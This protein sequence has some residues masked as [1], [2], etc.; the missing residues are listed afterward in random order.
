MPKILSEQRAITL[1]ITFDRE[2]TRQEVYNGIRDKILS[3]PEIKSYLICEEY[4]DKTGVPHF[5]GWVKATM[6]APTLKKRIRETFPLYVENTT[7][8]SAADVKKDSYFHYVLKGTP[9]DPP[10]VVFKQ[11][12]DYPEDVIQTHWQEAQ[13]MFHSSTSKT[14]RGPSATAIVDEVYQWAQDQQYENAYSDEAQMA[15]CG[16]LHEIYLDRKKS[17]NNFHLQSQLRWVMCKMSWKYLAE[18]T[19]R[20][21][22]AINK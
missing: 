9:T 6:S 3:L 20:V 18:N 13:S 8:Y 12:L 19:R 21:V 2:Y 11:T 15:I 5:Q 4:G 10:V 7:R 17:I 14:K 1:R 16:K 22:D